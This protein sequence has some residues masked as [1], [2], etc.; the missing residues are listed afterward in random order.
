MPPKKKKGSG[1]KKKGGK[2]RVGSKGAAG[3]SISVS[4]VGLK[5]REYLR[6]QVNDLKDQVTRLRESNRLLKGDRDAL[7]EIGTESTDRL[8]AEVDYFRRENLRHIDELEDE[9][10]KWIEGTENLRQEI[11]DVKE[12]IEKERAEA[13][14]REA[15]LKAEIV[16]L[17]HKLAG[18]EEFRDQEHAIRRQL[19]DVQGQ[20]QQ[21]EALFAD[22]KAGLERKLVEQQGMMAASIDERVA[23]VAKAFQQ[24]ADA[25]LNDRAEGAVQDN[26]RLERKLRDMNTQVK[27]VVDANDRLKKK[28]GDLKIELEIADDAQKTLSASARKSRKVS[29]TLRDRLVDEQSKVEELSDALAEARRTHR[30]ECDE[31]ERVIGAMRASL[32]ATQRTRKVE[33]AR[34]RDL[35]NMTQVETLIEW[36]IAEMETAYFA[37]SNELDTPDQKHAAAE[38]H[39]AQM[40]TLEL[41]LHAVPK[42]VRRVVATHPPPAEPKRRLHAAVKSVGVQ[43]GGPSFSSKTAKAAALGPKAPPA[44]RPRPSPV[45]NRYK[46]DTRAK[47]PRKPSGALRSENHLTTNRAPAERRRTQTGPHFGLDVFSLAAAIQAPPKALASTK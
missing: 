23:D 7:A 31:K 34:L 28:V 36:A 40:H 2:K 3:T 4:E 22:Q 46:L 42:V 10:R 47:S 18:L 1:S 35:S 26:L 24:E 17:N 15:E 33:S 8:R 12:Q 21:A 45:Q 37:R 38:Y 30:H 41:A 6:L 9:K 16:A 29:E 20:L 11:E 43:A 27:G 44:H 32:D 25:R 5:S 39:K 19:A 13:H 14:A